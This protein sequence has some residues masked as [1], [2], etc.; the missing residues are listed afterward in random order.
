M[1][2]N[3][4]EK[5]TQ[6]IFPVVGIGSSAGGVEALQAL[7]SNLSPSLKA[8][9]ILVQH[10]EP[11]R[12]SMLVDILSRAT[13]MPVAEAVGGTKIEP[14]R[15][16]VIPPNKFLSLQGDVLS[17]TAPVVDGVRMPIDF[18]FRSLAAERGDAVVGIV[19]T[20]TG[21]DGTVGLREIHGAGGI[22]MAQ[23]PYSA[24][25]PQMPESAIGTGIVDH[26]V[27]PEKMGELLERYVLHLPGVP[28]DVPSEVVEPVVQGV[29]AIVKQATGHDYSVYKWNTVYRRIGRR[30]SVLGIHN[31]QQYLQYV[32][33]H[34]E[35]A[36]LLFR[37][38]LIR[39]TSFFRDPDAFR[40]LKEEMLARLFANRPDG[41]TIRVWVAG[42]STGE[43]AYSIAM[44]LDEFGRASGRAF[45][46]Q[47][48]ATDLDETSI[49]QARAGSYPLD[50]AADVTEER[51][52]QFFVTEDHG[53][54]VKK[55]LRERIVFAVQNVLK[56]PPFTK[57]D[58]LVCRNLMIYL[59][60]EAQKSLVETFHYSLVPGGI[61]FLGSSETI[62]ARKELFESVGQ[63]WKFYEA[64]PTAGYPV[65][66]ADAHAPA[67]RLRP[68]VPIEVQ[69]REIAAKEA[70]RREILDHFSPPSVVVDEAGNVI[71]IQGKTGRF[72]EIAP[73]GPRFNIY[74]M[75]R[76]VIRPGLHT[77][78]RKAF[79]EK[80]EAASSNMVLSGE[81][82]ATGV[83][84]RAK[85]LPGLTGLFIV[86]FD[87]V[88]LPDGRAGQAETAG[89]DDRRITE[90]EDELRR[91][92]EDLQTMTEEF[93][94]AMEEQKSTNEELQSSNEELQSTNEELETSK[95]ELQSINEELTT[96]N[97]ELENKARQLAQAES[98]MKGLLDSV[99]LGAVFTDTELRIKSFT[100]DISQIA[101]LLPSDVGR[102]LTDLASSLVDTNVGE[103]ARR[104]L[105]SLQ[106]L[107]KE[108]Q[109]RTGM[110]H[111]MRIRPYRTSDNEIGGVVI[112]FTDITL[113]KK[114]AEDMAAAESLKAARDF[115]RATVNTVREP[116]LTLSEDLHIVT[117]NRSFHR[118]FSL[119]GQS[120]EG[121]LVYRIAG[122]QLDIPE[123][124]RLLEEVLPKNSF[125]EDFSLPY[126]AP[127]GPQRK[128]LLN[129]RTVTA[130]D[131]KRLPFILVGMNE[132]GK[133]V[134]E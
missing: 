131:G 70:A 34:R 110:W 9:F 98:D 71:Y 99:A 10:L 74:D 85:P 47:V 124:R 69:P 64:R 122:A 16:Y 83:R 114:S 63:K 93:Q 48:F 78:L 123:L 112:T 7:F 2:K 31:P 86:V 132:E 81:G 82:G 41:H 27:T 20:G 55:E 58:L 73:G 76:K 115:A 6:K 90:L 42:C 25:Y 96:V 15:A 60:P 84:V 43:E 102:P 30:M 12:P 75:A 21:S 49:E 128:L 57:L 38:L 56:D 91:T 72:L 125:I 52:R 95:E 97:A 89:T 127:G 100:S 107:E 11:H 22:T 88:I 101:N 120:A 61:L 14:G 80:A 29:L 35:E 113:L 36:G 65:F 129:A 17:L 23:E 118:L 4:Q 53:Y 87:E 133:Q 32:N 40:A 51:I 5:D 79:S 108:V 116:L 13:K 33:E 28:T 46:T 54:R 119:P 39:V 117:A 50:I 106:N 105:K 111:L 18:L 59:Q 26:V 130:S 92:R 19:L 44:I 77:T 134:G 94:T 109:D 67:Y 103:D 121:E 126:N 8:A 37:E 104:V 3:R 24:Q 45:G 66:Q 62:G 1:K 68:P